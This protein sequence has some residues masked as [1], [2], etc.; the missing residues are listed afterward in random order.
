M[1]LF[2]IACL[3][4]VSALVH[5]C[6]VSFSST[7]VLPP[8]VMLA[9]IALTLLSIALSLIANV[10]PCRERY[11]YC[12]AFG[13]C[14]LLST[15]T[16]CTSDCLRSSFRVFVMFV[17]IVPR[18]WVLPYVLSITKAR[19]R[20]LFCHMFMFD[21]KY[22]LKCVTV[23]DTVPVASSIFVAWGIVVPFCSSYQNIARSFMLLPCSSWLLI[24]KLISAQSKSEVL[25]I[26]IGCPMKLILLKQHLENFL[27]YV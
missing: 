22:L 21:M 17:F 1:M 19:F 13:F 15:N 20:V 25:C 12:R 5:I 23:A 6:I 24:L 2:C 3:P 7:G 16:V 27:R 26:S 10:V 9:N 14:A 4:F 11:R 18:L 8:G